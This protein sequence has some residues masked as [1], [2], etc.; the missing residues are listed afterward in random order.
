MGFSVTAVPPV[1]INGEVVSSTAIRN[2]LAKGDMEKVRRLT[3][4]FFSLHGRVIAGDGRGAKLGFPT[5]NIDI[6]PQHAIPADGIYVTRAYIDGKT[7][8]SVTNIGTRPTF[9]GG[10][11]TVEVYIIDFKGNLYGQ[12]LKI[13]ILKRL[14]KEKRFASIEGLKKQMA[15]DVK[16]SIVV[17]DSQE[18]N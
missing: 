15:R 6:D 12:D 14:R 9:D 13:D 17:L 8:K 10:S 3:G 16:Q 7:Y 18:K 11:R 4:R 1:K 5:A 2:A